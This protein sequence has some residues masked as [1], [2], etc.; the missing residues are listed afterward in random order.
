MKQRE[1]PTMIRLARVTQL[2]TS[3]SQVGRLT[4]MPVARSEAQGVPRWLAAA[5]NVVTSDRD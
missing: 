4:M 1:E 2:T 5:L 3:V